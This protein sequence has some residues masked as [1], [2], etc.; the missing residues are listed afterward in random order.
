MCV[1]MCV[2]VFYAQHSVSSHTSPSISFT[3]TSPYPPTPAPPPP[4]IISP[5][6]FTRRAPSPARW[7]SP[8][9]CCPSRCTS[10]R[11]EERDNMLCAVGAVW[12]C[13]LIQV[14]LS[15]CSSPPSPPPSSLSSSRYFDTRLPDACIYAWSIVAGTLKTAHVED[16]WR[17]GW[18]GVHSIH[19]IDSVF[20][21][22]HTYADK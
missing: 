3:T 15:F 11:R 16:G 17:V 7:G 1:C 9:A 13:M 14:W 19:S 22:T 2:C 12:Y 8:G 10:K 4:A 6:I 5:S 21:A 18:R 20:G